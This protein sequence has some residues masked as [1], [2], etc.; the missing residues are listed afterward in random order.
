MNLSAGG[1]REAGGAGRGGGEE[2]AI[3]N[4]VYSIVILRDHCLCQ[5]ERWEES[6]NKKTDDSLRACLCSVCGQKVGPPFQDVRAGGLHRGP[7]P[8]A[9]TN[10]IKS[11]IAT[12]V[13]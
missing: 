6:L 11:H 8:P 5:W 1:V 3:Q 9:G 10:S 7:L 13:W 4:K 2:Q 12:S